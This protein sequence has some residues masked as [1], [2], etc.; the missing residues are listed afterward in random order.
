MDNEH[1]YRL[2]IIAC[3]RA[4]EA[5]ILAD[6][7][8]ERRLAACVQIDSV[9]SSYR[10]Q[11]AVERAFEQRLMLKTRIDKVEAIAALARSLLSEENP[12]VIAL[13]ISEA[14][15]AYLAWLDESIDA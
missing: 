12:E 5:R 15:P 8:I 13:P 9:E 2:V 4:E 7:V 1:G 3:P 6:E 14:S 11:G 10:W